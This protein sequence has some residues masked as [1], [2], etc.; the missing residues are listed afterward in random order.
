MAFDPVSLNPRRPFPTKT[1]VR[2]LWV[3][4]LLAFAAAFFVPVRTTALRG[5]IVAGGLLIWGGA[6]FLFWKIVP[7]RVMCL[8]LALAPAL[9]LLLPD[10]PINTENLRNGYIAALQ[11]YEDTSFVEGGETTRGA[12]GSGLVRAALSV[13]EMRQGART[14]NAALLRKAA[15][16]WWNDGTARDLAAGYQG[17]TIALGQARSLN[18]ADTTNLCPGDLAIASDEVHVFAY[19]G[20]KSWIAAVP[21]EDK[22]VRFTIPSASNWAAVPVTLVR[23]RVLED[24]NR[25]GN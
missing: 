25:A 9:L 21:E 17:R 2:L 1:L 3:I 11:N 22:V 16:L 7:V 10:R 20:N 5:G 8:A 12:D 13:A 18:R 4:A 15:S 24:A 14:G 23:W 19:A 6:L